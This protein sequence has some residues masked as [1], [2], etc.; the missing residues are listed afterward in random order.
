MLCMYVQCHCRQQVWI[1]TL[2]LSRGLPHKCKTR[3]LHRGRIHKTLTIQCTNITL[4]LKKSA[5][6][7]SPSR[8]SGL[9]VSHCSKFRAAFCHCFAPCSCPVSC[10]CYCC[11]DPFI[12]RSAQTCP[13]FTG[14]TQPCTSVSMFTINVD[15][16]LFLCCSSVNGSVTGSSSSCIG[17]WD[18]WSV[19]YQSF[20]LAVL[21]Q[22]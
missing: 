12:V 4:V 19:E 10:N 9:C 14:F 1:L 7:L 21:L 8:I 6:S 20:E 22:Y 15:N 13:P 5:L 3:E 17:V 2:L 16:C 18:P 11:H